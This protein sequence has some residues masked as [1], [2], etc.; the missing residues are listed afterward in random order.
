MSRTCNEKV[1]VQLEDDAFE[2]ADSEEYI[3]DPKKGCGDET[4]PTT[5]GA[6]AQV[7]NEES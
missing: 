6:L 7:P 5:G 4:D 3:V 1:N 2:L